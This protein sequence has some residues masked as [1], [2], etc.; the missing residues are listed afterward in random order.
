VE[1]SM[2]WTEKRWAAL[3][4]GCVFLGMV[5]LLCGFTS[6]TLIPEQAELVTSD[7]EHFWQA[8]DDAAKVALAERAGVYAKEYLDLGSE[9][10]REFSKR[11]IGSP[12]VF[13]Q[14][15]EENRAYYGRA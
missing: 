1:I 11:R 15:I 2:T 5:A 8:F 10:L 14:H 13:T 12:E 4:K 3:L 6:T 9:G 7:V